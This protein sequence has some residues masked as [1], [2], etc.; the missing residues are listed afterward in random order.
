MVKA[1]KMSQGESAGP[2]I[3]VNHPEVACFGSATPNTCSKN[4][5]IFCSAPISQLFGQELHKDGIAMFLIHGVQAGG[6]GGPPTIFLATT[7]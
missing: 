4:V 6:A 2:I 3:Y 7:M 5:S 1:M